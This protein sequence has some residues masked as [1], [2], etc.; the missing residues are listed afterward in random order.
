M[1]IVR[2]GAYGWLIKFIEH[3]I[4]DRRVLRLI[5]KWPRAGV[6]EQGKRVTTKVG[7]RKGQ[8]YR[9]CRPTSVCTT[10]STCGLSNGGGEMD[11]L[12]SSSCA[13]LLCTSSR[14]ATVP[15][16]ASRLAR[17]KLELHPEKTRL[18]RFGRFASAQC[19]ERGES[20]APLTFNFLGL[21]HC[22][23][24]S[25]QWKFLLQ[26]HTVRTRLTAKF[27]EVKTRTSP[28]PA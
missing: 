11:M 9:R 18:L 21:T 6:M 25:R 15:E 4:A 10:R 27:R 1:T 13:T 8:R 26:R 20:G 19:K 2:S 12:T 16:G 28:S 17:F 7:S 22:C 5:Q 23:S 3:R 24:R 14:W